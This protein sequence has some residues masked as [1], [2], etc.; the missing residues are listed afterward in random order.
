MEI[1]ITTCTGCVV[2]HNLTKYCLKWT[3]DENLIY[4]TLHACLNAFICKSVYPYVFQTLETNRFVLATNVLVPGTYECVFVVCGFHLYHI[5]TQW[6]RLSLIDWLHHIISVGASTHLLIKV[7]HVVGL[8]TLFFICGLPGLV[9][10]L[11]LIG[12]K[13]GLITRI[14]QKYISSMVHITLRMPGIMWC[15]FLGY[16]IG[17]ERPNHVYVVMTCILSAVNG[18]YFG[19]DAICSYGKALGQLGGRTA[20]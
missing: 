10:Y 11:V 12:M 5:F 3:V 2:I 14:T 1:I 9:E 20:Q 16:Q 6:T 4:F 8:A 19:Y 17:V 7:D 18:L 15:C 13:V